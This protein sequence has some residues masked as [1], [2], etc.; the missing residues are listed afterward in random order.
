MKLPID[1][2]ETVTLHSL[3]L[4]TLATILLL[5]AFAVVFVFG[6]GQPQEEKTE[7]MPFKTQSNKKS[8]GSKKT[9]LTSKT[10]SA[11]KPSTTKKAKSDD[12]TRSVHG[13]PDK[14]QLLAPN[15][16]KLKSHLKTAGSDANNQEPSTV[17]Y[18]RVEPRKTEKFLEDNNTL[19]S[20]IPAPDEEL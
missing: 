9:R 4:N 19:A 1:F 6:C 17:S 5:V 16:N 15:L 10:N 8:M 12:K 7:E 11:P 3:S 20:V 13:L 2:S 18:A 14:S